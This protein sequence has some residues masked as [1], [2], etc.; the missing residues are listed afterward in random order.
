MCCL[1]L[2]NNDKTID[3]CKKALEIDSNNVKALFRRAH[4]YR[5]KKE[6]EFAMSDLVRA[7]KVEPENNDVQ[8][9][10]NQVSLMMIHKPNGYSDTIIFTTS[11]VKVL[12]EEQKK[13]ERAAYSRMFQ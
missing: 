9:A 1:K 8:K 11:Q 2:N 4:A 12:I 13:K 10:I 3:M 7:S 5:N 6:Y